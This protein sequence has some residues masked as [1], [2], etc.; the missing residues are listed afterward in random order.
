MTESPVR[1]ARLHRWLLGDRRLF[2]RY[3]RVV[4]T[5]PSSTPNAL[6]AVLAGSAA[7]VA[8]LAMI[9]WR[10]ELARAVNRRQRKPGRSTAGPRSP[11][12]AVAIG[13][14]IAALGIL[15]FAAGITDRFGQGF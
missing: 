4:V 10:H 5:D 6:L 13:I 2:L 3:R 15:A 14:F 1:E 11:R 8:G 7:V 9:W 12:L